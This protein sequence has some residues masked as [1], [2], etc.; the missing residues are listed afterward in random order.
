MRKILAGFIVGVFI[1]ACGGAA[2]SNRNDTVFH[3]DNYREFFKQEGHGDKNYLYTRTE[4]DAP[5]PGKCYVYTFASETAGAVVCT[6]EE[7]TS[8]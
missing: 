5:A 8:Q 2:A 7:S 4:Q 6:P 1:A 3:E